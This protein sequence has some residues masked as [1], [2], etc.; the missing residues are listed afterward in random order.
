MY[1]LRRLTEQYLDLILDWRNKP[2]IRQNM[3]STQII[4]KDEHYA[5]FEKIR[6][7]KSKEYFICTSND[8]PVGVIYFVDINFKHKNTVWGFYS[9]DLSKRGIGI[10][11]GFLG[12]NYIF[13][14][15]EFEKL[16]GEVLSFN[17]LALEFHRT[18]GFQTEGIF[19][20]HYFT[21]SEYV[22]VYRLAIYKNDWLKR[23]RFE[24]QNKISLE[25]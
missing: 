7:D 6:Q 17:K 13:E 14:K 16:S 1:E 21:G 20:N 12:L 22:D 8:Q 5:W 10:N 18:L 3:F 19:K 15:L 25:R 2:A 11:M 4:T 9:G 23:S 24:I